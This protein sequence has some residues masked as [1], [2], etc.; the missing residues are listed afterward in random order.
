MRAALAERFGCDAERIVCGTGSDELITM[1]IRAYA[2]PGDEVIHSA[3]GFLMYAIAAR[4][5]GAT[6]VAAPEAN[7][8]V[9][10]GAMLA[11]VTERTKMVLIANPNNP[12]G[13]YISADELQRLQ[14]GLPGHV[15][16]V[17]DAA[18]AEY[19]SRNDYTAGAGM[20]EEFD[21]VVMTRTFSK[22]FGLAAVRLGWAY[23]PP[24]YRRCPE[25]GAQPVQCNHRGAG[26]RPRGAWRYRPYRPGTRTQRYLAAVA[27]RRIEP[28]GPDSASIRRQ[29]RHGA[30]QR[31]RCCNRSL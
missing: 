7:F 26:R 10:V 22:I 14:E 18:Y 31:C 5:A 24:A 12:T 1:L 19:V 6:P 2:G 23:C 15:V 30:L 28:A 9:D 27:D 21:N 25:S 13:S 16:L 3:H 4:G 20:V 8:T 29:F 17:I 11:A